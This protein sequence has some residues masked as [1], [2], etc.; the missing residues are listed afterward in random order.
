MGSCGFDRVVLTS[1]DDCECEVVS[2]Y[3]ASDEAREAVIVA[4]RE[5]LAPLSYK[6]LEADAVRRRRPVLVNGLGGSAL[7]AYEMMRRLAS[8]SYVVAPVIALGRVVALVHADCLTRTL[9][10]EDRDALGTLAVGLGEVVARLEMAH[11]LRSTGRA[12]QRL[13]TDV[14]EEMRATMSASCQLRVPGPED[15]TPDSRSETSR[16]ENVLSRREIEV[17]GLMADGETNRQ[18]AARL[19]IAEGT[20]K[21]HVKSIL[22]KLHAANRADAVS[23]Y[24]RLAARPAFA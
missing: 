6:T 5:P 22:R 21:S 13:A 19:V 8:T 12:V 20:V 17:L 1:L 14:H 24:L 15:E 16:L 10:D 18:I 3:A 2:C 23:R 9:D 4:L 11:R 7:T